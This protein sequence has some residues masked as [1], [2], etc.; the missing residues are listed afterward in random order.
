MDNLK[1][2]ILEKIVYIVFGIIIFCFIG[3]IFFVG[4]DIFKKERLKDRFKKGEISVEEFCENYKTNKQIPA[5]CYNYFG[6][7]PNGETCRMV[8]KVMT[9][10]TNYLPK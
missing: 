2:Q 8:G 10:E 5:V 9:C 3:I 7:K 1:W 4:K 6:V